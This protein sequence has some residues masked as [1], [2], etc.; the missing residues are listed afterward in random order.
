MATPIKFEVQ[1][2]LAIGRRGIALR[3]AILKAWG[4]VQ[5]E[6]PQRGWWRRKGTRAA[7]MWEHTVKNGI[8][9]LSDD[10]LVLP[11]N[12]TVSL[13]F[14][15]KVL[16]RA[17]KADLELKSRNYPTPLAQLFH[18]PDADLFGYEGL[19]RVEYEGLQRV[20]LVYVLNQFETAIDWVGIVARER[21]V[22]LWHFE[23]EEEAVAVEK[24]PIEAPASE[25]AEQETAA[26]IA[27][28][29]KG[30]SDAKKKSDKDE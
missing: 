17:K 21:D 10:A 11:H 6:Y 1:A 15:D 18:E 24:L 8:E 26:D 3:K 20:E 29:K 14:D 30:S 13:V 19:Q 12:D 2:V 25:P 7:V 9:A 4:E 5:D 23:L 16:V 22:V 28:L 27:K